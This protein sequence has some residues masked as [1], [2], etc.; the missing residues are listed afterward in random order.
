MLAMAW[1]FVGVVALLATIGGVLTEDDGV[2]IVAGV[3]GFVSWGIWTFGALDLQVASS[4]GLQ[5]VSMPELALLGVALALLPG[6]IALTG[7]VQII[8]RAKSG[9]VDDL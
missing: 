8:S 5:T 1:V 7:P 6:Y 4:G 2:A 9:N 3:V